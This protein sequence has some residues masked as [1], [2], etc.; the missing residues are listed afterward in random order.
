[1]NLCTTLSPDDYS[2][3]A[4]ECALFE[5]A[6]RRVNPRV[7]H[8]HRRWEYGV[9]LRALRQ[10]GCRTVLDVGGANCAL[11]PMCAL[12][13]MA[14]TL[15]DPHPDVALTGNY[16]RAFPVPVRWLRDDLLAVASTLPAADGVACMSVLEHIA[17]DRAFFDK[18]L[19]HA[20][21]C[22]VITVDFSPD[23]G[24]YSEHHLRTYNAKALRGLV[25][26]AKRQGW[27]LVSR[28]EWKDRGAFVDA[29]SFAS[30]VLEPK[31]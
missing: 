2:H 15:I 26:R 16:A 22:V 5:Q 8:E 11:T 3:L 18:L 12:D 14:V 4:D 17:D 1:M 10:A 24:V 31:P 25:T 13:G 20:T 28:P 23:G 30:L 21:R 9:A 6:R 27:Q 29:Y 19:A 7:D